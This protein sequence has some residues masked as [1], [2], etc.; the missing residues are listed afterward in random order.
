MALAPQVLERLL[1]ITDRQT[2]ARESQD[3]SGT[4]SLADL[5]R[6][7]ARAAALAPAPVPVRLAI[8]HTYTSE[9]LDPWLEG[10]AAL[11][12]LEP[13]VYHAPYGV[14]HGEAQPGSD[15]VAH[16]PDMTVLLLRHEDLHPQLGMPLVGL[17]AS[18]AERLL[19]AALDE[20]KTLV[21]ALRSHPV[22]HLVVALL[23][24]F[25][26]PALG[27]HDQQAERSETRFLHRLHDELA[28]WMR[29]TVPS[30]TCLDMDELVRQVGRQRV[31]DARHWL[32]ARFPFSSEASFEL[33][34]R[35]MGLAR[36]LKTERA[37][38]LVLDAD[39]TLWGGVIGEDGLDGI[40]LGPDYPGNAYM[41]FQRRLLDFQQRG[42]ILAMCSK[43]N[44]ADVDEVLN[45]HP[46]QLLKAQHFV[47]KRV[48]W[49]PKPANLVSLAKELGLGLESFI[50]VDDSDH[51]CAAVR[52]ELPQV[53]VVQVPKRAHEV[54]RCLDRVARLEILNLTAEDRAK[55]DMYRAE[56]QRRQVLDAVDE[57]GAAGGGMSHLSRLGMRMTV[58]LD[59]LG[60]V[61]RLAQLTQK[62]NQFNLTTRR[63]GEQEVA[64]FIASKD[65]LVLDFSLKD[66]FGDSGIVGLALVQLNASGGATLDSFMMS[67]RVI[68]RCA[69]EAFMHAVLS[70]VRA[71]GH[72]MLHAC[73]LPTH[74]NA[75]VKDLLPRLGFETQGDGSGLY[76][77][78]L[79]DDALQLPADFPIEIEWKGD[80]SPPRHRM[81]AP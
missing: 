74:K 7:G 52:A 44:A 4:L 37:K 13:S 6:L 73:F 81:P 46:H 47:A 79:T 33:S 10:A 53:E 75:L 70:A 42:F 26:G 71:R 49:E 29:A 56:Q 60:H 20:I 32:T 45:S 1:A 31:F 3:Q 35:M 59:P 67:C 9:L 25:S 27:W 21:A 63:Y 14:T 22:G 78:H 76:V 2:L 8:L 65:W 23:P 72:E 55:T 39:N 41:A 11:M 40:A 54:P 43:N 15:L 28:Q 64:A 36:L 34:M 50:F 68:G 24:A 69:E 18:E 12:G 19:V 66:V 62:T 80:D 30:S 77:R 48:N 17:E 51:E 5:R 16:R 38:V 58:Q 61:P 57:R